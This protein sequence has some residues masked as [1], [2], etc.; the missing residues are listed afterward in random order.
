MLSR[1]LGKKREHTTRSTTDRTTS[2]SKQTKEKRSSPSPDFT[3]LAARGQ[4]KIQT[5]VGRSVVDP[6]SAPAA[7]IH[8]NESST[9]TCS[10]TKS[11][12]GVRYGASQ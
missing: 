11:T 6:S 12:T 8:N 3:A 10:R 4:E 5:I 7:T 2:C 1:L 9:I